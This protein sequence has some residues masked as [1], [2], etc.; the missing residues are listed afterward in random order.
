MVYVPSPT[1]DLVTKLVKENP[2][3]SPMQIHELSLE[4]RHRTLKSIQNALGYLWENHVLW[5]Q[6]QI[7][8]RS[9]G[10]RCWSHIYF[11]YGSA[12]HLKFAE[13]NKIQV[14]P[15]QSVIEAIDF[16][17]V[18]YQPGAV[19]SLESLALI[20][21]HAVKNQAALRPQEP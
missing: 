5:R 3:S 11:I 15:K 4:Y 17:D 18:G 7:V 10:S 21:I 20:T 1:S 13:E 16:G 12:D 6:K 14:Q 8:T 2:G 9:N 19:P